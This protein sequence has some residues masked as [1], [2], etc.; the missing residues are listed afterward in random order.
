MN[1][2]LPDELERG[3][4]ALVSWLLSGELKQLFE[5]KH[6]YQAIDIVVDDATMTKARALLDEFRNRERMT[7]LA[8]S[9]ASPSRGRTY[10]GLGD[11]ALRAGIGFMLAGWRWGALRPADSQ[12]RLVAAVPG[13][14][15]LSFGLD[16]A[17]AYC[18][19]CGERFPSNLTA[20]EEVMASGPAGLGGLAPQNM[21]AQ[22]FAFN[23]QC[24][25]CKGLPV[26]YLVHRVG[27]KVSL[28][29][30][31]PIEVT[32]VP[33]VLPKMVRAYY[34]D[35]VVAH[36]SGKILAGLFYLRVLVEQYCYSGLTG[37]QL[38]ADQ[39]IERYMESLPDDFK[40]H[41]PSLK[42]VYGRLSVALHKATADGDLFDQCLGDIEWHFEA[43]R[44]R[45]DLPA[46]GSPRVTGR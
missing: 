34:S 35:A 40:T 18:P 12:A 23:F 45:R 14:R 21:V 11:E 2:G 38:L 22:V 25:G 31:A 13:E 30:R 43:R 3:L 28:S 9:E 36:Q 20:C 16:G 29:G 6:L 42:D 15:L 39:A 41:S 33:R 32:P 5:T 7:S 17:L 46:W 1:T 37:E 4:A 26:V 10:G 44:A 27:S 24:Q 19:R 8:M